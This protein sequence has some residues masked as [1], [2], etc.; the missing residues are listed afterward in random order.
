MAEHTCTATVPWSGVVPH[1]PGCQEQFSK[2]F[3]KEKEVLDAVVAFVGSDR[4]VDDGTLMRVGR[5]YAELRKQS[6]RG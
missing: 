2:L 5:E 6:G 3:A 4:G 1:C